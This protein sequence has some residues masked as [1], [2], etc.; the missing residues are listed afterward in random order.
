MNLLVGRKPKEEEVI[1]L[2]FYSCDLRITLVHY[3]R[4]QQ[5]YHR[6]VVAQNCITDNSDGLSLSR[7]AKCDP[8][9]NRD[10][11]TDFF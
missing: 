10:P 3:G 2:Y 8:S 5:W 9:Q 4:L 7:W 1:F 11:L 6:R